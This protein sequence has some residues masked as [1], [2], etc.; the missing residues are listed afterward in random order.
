MNDTLFKI[1]GKL[2]GKTITSGDVVKCQCGPYITF[3]RV[4]DDGGHFCIFGPGPWAF[5]V[6]LSHFIDQG[7]TAE[8][9]KPIDVYRFCKKHGWD[10]KMELLKFKR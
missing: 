8:V 7:N 4:I 2:N 9:V 10:A 3:S 6:E 5:K 1:T